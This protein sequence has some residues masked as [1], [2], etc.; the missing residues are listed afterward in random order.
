MNS[1]PQHSTNT[2]A[3]QESMPTPI[4]FRHSSILLSYS[5]SGNG[6]GGCGSVSETSIEMLANL[7]GD[8]KASSESQLYEA[9]CGFESTF[10]NV[11][12]EASKK[13]PLARTETVCFMI[14]SC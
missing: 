7:C 13:G 10:D 4:F 11:R 12:A 8:L 3:L 1:I 14:T 2:P 6:S 5:N 9:Y